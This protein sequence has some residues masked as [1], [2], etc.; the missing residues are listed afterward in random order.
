MN[1]SDFAAQYERLTTD[2]LANFNPADLVPEAL[3]AYQAELR[4]RADPQYQQAERLRFRA[5][6]K[7]PNPRLIKPISIG[8]KRGALAVWLGI[9]LAAGLSLL[10]SSGS[11]L[12]ADLKPLWLSAFIYGLIIISGWP[13]KRDR[14]L[15]F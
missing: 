4:R 6:K 2:E 14:H 8:R 10:R 11:R 3:A 15:R 13:R 1:Q 7:N 12:S 5:M 9:N